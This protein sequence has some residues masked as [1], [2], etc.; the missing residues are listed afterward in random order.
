M[1]EFLDRQA[2]G[3]HVII[4]FVAALSVLLTANVSA[5]ASIGR[6]VA[7]GCSTWPGAQRNRGRLAATP[8]WLHP[9]SGRPRAHGGFPLASPC[10]SLSD[11]ALSHDDSRH[12][13]QSVRPSEV[14]SLA[15][16]SGKHP[17]HGRTPS[18]KEQSAAIRASEQLG[19]LAWWSH[20][21]RIPF[22]RSIDDRALTSDIPVNEHGPD[23]HQGMPHR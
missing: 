22:I 4:M 8:R 19:V 17:C 5:R 9:H 13:L 10:T 15:R 16:V 7:R 12:P 23:G 2:T 6:P 3:R 14:R 11:A 1:I 21:L 20:F 18:V